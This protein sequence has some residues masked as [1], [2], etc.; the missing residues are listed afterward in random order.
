MSTSGLKISRCEDCFEW[1]GQ[2]FAREHSQGAQ[3]KG[4][5][6]L[7]D[8]KLYNCGFERRVKIGDIIKISKK[9]T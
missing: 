2:C 3:W 1:R 9:H 4:N 6:P 7:W 8:H 5:D